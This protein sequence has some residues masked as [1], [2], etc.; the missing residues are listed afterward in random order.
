MHFSKGN[1]RFIAAK[2]NRNTLYLK[3]KPSDIYS[4]NSESIDR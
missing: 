3:T 2:F 1:N 4:C